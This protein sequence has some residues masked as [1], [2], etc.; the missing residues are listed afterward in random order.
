MTKM[1]LLRLQKKRTWS[2]HN[3]KTQWNSIHHKYLV[4]EALLHGKKII[5]VK[6]NKRKM[7]EKEK[8]T[9]NLQATQ[10]DQCDDP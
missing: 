3:K 1:L 5:D 7:M 6:N 2:L 9:C 8:L 10:D 4:L